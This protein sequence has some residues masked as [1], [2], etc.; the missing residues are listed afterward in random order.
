MKKI[1]KNKKKLE[2]CAGYSNLD[3]LE[4]SSPCQPRLFLENIHIN[5]A[6]CRTHSYLHSHH[7]QHRKARTMQRTRSGT[8]V[9]PLEAE[10]NQDDPP[11][12]PLRQ[13]APSYLEPL[14]TCALASRDTTT[15]ASQSSESSPSSG[16]MKLFLEERESKD[17]PQQSCWKLCWEP[18]V[19]CAL[20]LLWLPQLPLLPR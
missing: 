18:W 17:H 8:H 19:S 12:M 11:E 4:S 14:G 15:C 2:F 20:C 1:F 3:S 13:T 16:T 7:K 5:C 6:P 9:C 10:W